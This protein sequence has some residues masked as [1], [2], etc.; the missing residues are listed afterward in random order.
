MSQSFIWVIIILSGMF[1]LLLL[2]LDFRLLDLIF[3]IIL[4]EMRRFT[5]VLMVEIRLISQFI[6]QLG[7]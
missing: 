4:K 5:L 3:F 7:L 6:L 1:L 2:N